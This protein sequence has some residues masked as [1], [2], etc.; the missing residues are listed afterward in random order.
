VYRLVHARAL[1]ASGS[2]GRD[3]GS[4]VAAGSFLAIGPGGREFAL[5]A[6]GASSGYSRARVGEAF[7]V[8][9]VRGPPGLRF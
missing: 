4:A 5:V 3:A 8:R 6:E 2:A 7:C 1:E 9:D